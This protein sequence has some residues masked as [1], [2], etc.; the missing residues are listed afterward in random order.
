MN[1]TAR[2]AP[3]LASLGLRIGIVAAGALILANAVLAWIALGAVERRLEPVVEE[4]ARVLARSIANDLATAARLDIP[5]AEL[6]GVGAYLDNVLADHPET[7]YVA[8][9]DEAD[10]LLF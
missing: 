10:R 6:S 2:R 5:I 3:T 1:A 8:V 9:T 7:A 4:K